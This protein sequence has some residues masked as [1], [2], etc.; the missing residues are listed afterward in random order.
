M[1]LTI[2]TALANL[3]PALPEEEAYLALFQ[4]A[5]HVAADCDGQPPRRQRAPLES[6]PESAALKRWLRRWTKVRHR[7]AAERT[8]LTGI[9][10]DLSPAALADALL[11]A[12][13]ERAFADGGH[14]LDFINKAF[15]CLDVIGWGHASSVLPT[16]VGQMVAARGARNRPNGANLSI[17]WRFA[18]KPPAN[19][20]SFSPKVAARVAGRTTRR[21]RGSC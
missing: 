16:V 18:T 10:A 21:S 13:T 5:R 2:L 11:A 1:G 20:R 14:S 3:L 4:G 17:L 12:E 9:A 6:R 7:E 19:C 8:L 15:E